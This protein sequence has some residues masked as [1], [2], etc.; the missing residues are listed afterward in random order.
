ML[1]AVLGSEACLVT[2]EE[3]AFL[4]LHGPIFRLRSTRD[5]PSFLSTILI[6]QVG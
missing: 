2:D 3:R 5:S 6:F 1:T 4:A